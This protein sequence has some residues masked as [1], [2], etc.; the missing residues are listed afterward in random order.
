MFCDMDVHEVKDPT[1]VFEVQGLRVGGMRG[2]NYIYGGWSDEL[3]PR[4][5][6][7]RARLVPN[8]I[9][10]LVTHAPPMNILD[11]VGTDH[12]GMS[13][14]AHYVNRRMMDGSP[15]LVHA[16]GHIHERGS[17]VFTLERTRFSNAAC[18]MNVI[19]L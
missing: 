13:G 9:D 17:E 11:N 19:D 1:D 5:G 15:L 4:D 14:L 18:G 6:M 2:I 8:S 12:Y 10:I 16:F 7:E 3:L